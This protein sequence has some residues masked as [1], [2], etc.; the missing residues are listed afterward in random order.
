MNINKITDFILLNST[1]KLS[2]RQL[3]G[4]LRNRL[5]T[6]RF[7][8]SFQ[9]EELYDESSRKTVDGYHRRID[10]STGRSETVAEFPRAVGLKGDRW[11]LSRYSKHLSLVA[12]P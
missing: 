2:Y 3:A 5:R 10:G 12:T 11:N 1:Y 6:E 4:K 9:A 7:G 8:V